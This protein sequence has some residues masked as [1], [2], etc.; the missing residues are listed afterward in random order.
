MHDAMFGD[1]NSLTQPALLE[2]AGRIGLDIDAFKSCLSDPATTSA[3]D[4][5]TRAASELNINGTP[6]FLIN[7]RPLNGVVPLER[8]EAIINDEM[9]RAPPARG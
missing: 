4:A 5:D 8:F 2:T 6:Y 3:I 7:G 9:H 1:Q